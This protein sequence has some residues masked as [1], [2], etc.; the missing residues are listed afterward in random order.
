MRKRL[1]KAALLR[2]SRERKRAERRSVTSTRAAATRA[3][4]ARTPPSLLPVLVSAMNEPEEDWRGRAALGCYAS[5]YVDVMGCEDD[6]LRHAAERRVATAQLARLVDHLEE[7]ESP[8]E[9]IE[10]AVARCSKGPGYPS[11]RV[12]SVTAIVFRWILLK[13]WR[14]ARSRKDRRRTART[15]D[16]KPRSRTW[17]EGK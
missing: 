6:V 3:R 4:M 9:Y 7:G 16:A 11:D 5:A 12:P 2:E 13:N 8:R 15:A 1:S 14:A 17:A 10:W